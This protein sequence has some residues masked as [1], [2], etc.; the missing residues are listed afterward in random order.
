LASENQTATTHELQQESL[1]VRP[2]R[3]STP[4]KSVAL[5]L[6]VTFAIMFGFWLIFSGRFDRFHLTLGLISCALVAFFSHDLLFPAGLKLNFLGRWIQFARYI[7][8]LL[9]QILLANLHLLRLCFHPRMMELIDPHI[10]EFGSRLD[11]NI[12][13]TTFANSITLTPGTITVN[14]SLLGRFTIHCIDRASGKPLPGEMER[15][16][17]GVFKE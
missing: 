6:G 5:P 2:A 15:R 10:I 7:P 13:R 17:A 1:N 4:K 3:P 16:V 12:A 14:V 9:Y 8:W 11:S